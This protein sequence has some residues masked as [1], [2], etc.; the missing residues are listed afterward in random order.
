M[1]FTAEPRTSTRPAVGNECTTLAMCDRAVRFASATLTSS[2]APVGRTAKQLVWEHN[3]IKLYRYDPRRTIVYPVPLLF[4]HSLIAR[5]YILDL[6]PGTS[7]I[8]YLLDRG[9]DVYLIDWGVPTTHLRLEDYVLGYLPQ[10]LKTMRGESQAAEL[11][12]L[13][14]CLGGT[15][16]LLYAATHPDSAV[17][18]IV[19]VATPVNF[20]PM[21]LSRTWPSVP[22]D[23]CLQIAMDRWVDASGNIPAEVIKTNFQIFRSLHPAN[24]FSWYL[25][26]WEHLDD[27]EYVAYF[28]ALDRWAQDH[29]PFPGEVFRQITENFVRDNKLI[30]DGFELGGRC[31]KLRSIRQAFLA[32]A[33]ESD[34]LVPLAATDMQV[35]L[36]SSADKDFLTVPGGHVSLVAGRESRMTVWPRVAEWLATRSRALASESGVAAGKLAERSG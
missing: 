8:E 35:D 6:V 33:A 25:S 26:L 28:R 19:S 15:L 2:T 4:V 30:R 9:F 23:P 12:L 32:I 36:V 5:S 17:R 13:G 27:A 29:I 14:Y 1:S 21:A 10:A 18:N 24:E 7:F 22:G 16:V 31:A 11:S 34:L 20:R 3:Q